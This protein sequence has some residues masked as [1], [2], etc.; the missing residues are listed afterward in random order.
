MK[1]VWNKLAVACLAL[2]LLGSCNNPQGPANIPGTI[3]NGQVSASP[4]GNAGSAHNLADEA[5]AETFAMNA[6][7]QSRLAW[8]DAVAR[9]YISLSENPLIAAANKTG[10][11]DGFLW[12]RLEKRSEAT[13]VVLHIGHNVKDKDGA[14]FATDGWLYVDTATRQV[15]EC[16]IATDELTKWV[17]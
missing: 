15:Y 12:D 7:T 5:N 8:A 6:A 9:N 11:P 14:R 10:K 17:K 1:N 16:D 3:Q 4:M 2:A 13:Y